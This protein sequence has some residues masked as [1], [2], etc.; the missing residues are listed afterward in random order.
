MTAA[1]GGM[2]DLAAMQAQ[3]NAAGAGEDIE[4]LLAGLSE[5]T[6]ASAAGGGYSEQGLA[7]WSKPPAANAAAGGFGYHKSG[8]QAAVQE[9]IEAL[10]AGLSEEDRQLFESL[11][12]EQQAALL[13]TLTPAPGGR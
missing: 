12:P 5:A 8:T 4:A 3:A 9:D 6:P 2:A 10:L 7:P 11:T 1:S 13:A